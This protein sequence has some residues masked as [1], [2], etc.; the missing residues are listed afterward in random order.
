MP[1]GSGDYVILY[2]P[3][4]P[5]RHSLLTLMAPPLLQ[6]LSY[7]S[8]A[9]RVLTL[10]ELL[11]T[12]FSFGTRASNV[13]SALVCRSWREIAL[14]QVWREIDDIYY[15]LDILT[16]LNRRVDTGFYVR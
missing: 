12:I 14:D 15:L 2:Q 7:Q 16:P 9:Q 1:P 4:V 11:Q 8:T 6:S 10:P 3:R 5:I 13:S